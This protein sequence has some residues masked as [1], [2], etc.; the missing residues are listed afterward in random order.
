MR[1]NRLVITHELLLPTTHSEMHKEKVKHFIE[2]QSPARTMM[3]RNM[4]SCIKSDGE[5][6]AARISIASIT[7]NGQL[8]GI[9]TIHDFS[10]I[11]EFVE[12][13]RSK[14]ITDPL[15]NLF[16]R[17]HLNIL[18]EKQSQA[19]FNSNCMGV[20]YIDL[21]KFKS[22]NDS[23]GHGTGD[24]LLKEV[25]RRLTE[26][27]CSNDI[28]FRLGGDE[29]LVLFNLTKH[30]DKTSESKSIAN[31]LDKLISTPVYIGTLGH[32]ITI[33]AN[34]GI[35]IY[36]DDSSS[37]STLI[38]LADKAMYRAK[39]ANEPYICFSEMRI[40]STVV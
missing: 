17:R 9:A 28:C 15:T 27:L 36:P 6:F 8:C 7:L 4:L 18:L 29:F 5:A 26:S 19:I 11:Q 16:N 37:L 31:K 22:I 33:S 30:H 20:A 13:L 1:K 38:D 23:F 2:N 34:I 12:D 39:I 32:E 35:S 21:N 25:S 24:L 3:S 40:D 10:T 14:V